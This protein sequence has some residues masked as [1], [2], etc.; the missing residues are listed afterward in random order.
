MSL[1]YEINITYTRKKNI[2]KISTQHK[3]DIPLL[4]KHAS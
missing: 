3:F 4:N 2:T 1:K